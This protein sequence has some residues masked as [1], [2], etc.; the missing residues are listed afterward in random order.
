MDAVSA[1]QC[2][3]LDSHDKDDYWDVASSDEDITDSDS[4]GVIVIYADF[5][6]EACTAEIRSRSFGASC[7]HIVLRFV[8][9]EA[10]V[11]CSVVSLVG[12]LVGWLVV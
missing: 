9:T 6:S 1:E 8:A 4:H 10:R 2:I 3:G 7:C 11:V 5:V 12:W